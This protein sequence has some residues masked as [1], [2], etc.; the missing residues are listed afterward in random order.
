M[1]HEQGTLYWR[2]GCG[3]CARLRQGLREADIQL[4]EVNIWEDLD[5]AEIVRGFAN[6]NETV[7]TVVIG[8]RGL[9]N[10]SVKAVRKA[11]D[12]VDDRAD[13]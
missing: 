13:R 4:R 3:F 2:P 8:D 12:R 10:P 9:V 7:P 6:G 11:L 5:A 1:T